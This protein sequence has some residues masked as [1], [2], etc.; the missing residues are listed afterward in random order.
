MKRFNHLFIPFISIILFSFS[1]LNGQ[2]NET[3][4]WLNDYKGEIPAGSY[5]YKYE[6][7]FFKKELCGI[8]IKSIKIDKKGSESV[9]RYELYL[10]DIDENAIKFKVTGK[11][12]TVSI[13]TK[14][15]QKFIKYFEDD[16]F[17][18][19]VSSLDI[20]TDQV[21]K[22]RALVDV[23]KE[24]LTDCKRQDKSWGS[25]K[26]S[27]GWLANNISAAN[28]GGT[29]YLQSFS[30]DGTRNYL[31][32]YNR[33]YNDSKGNEIVEVYSFNLADVDPAEVN[34][35]VSGKDLSVEL[36]TKNNDK[37]FRIMKD[38]AVQNYDNDFE[39]FVSSL[40]EAR[41]M[42]QALKF[43]IPLCKPV[44]KSFSD[45]NQALI[46][47]KE[48]VKEMTS[49]NYTYVQ[50]LDYENKP[51][52]I[53]SVVSKRTDSKGTTVED[54]YLLYLN[55]LEPEVALS[56]SG[57]DVLLKLNVKDKQKLI[58][59]FKDDEL[60]NYSNQIEI[61][62]GDIESARE[63]ANAFNYAI[64]NRDPGILKWADTGKAAAWISLNIGSITEAGKTYEQNLSF[65]AGNNYKTVLNLKTTDGSSETDEIF[66]FYM[67]DI[68]KDKLE[69][70]T[71][72]KKM[73]VEVTTGKE[74]VVKVFKSNEIQNYTS[75]VDL[76]FE[77]TRQAR[78]FI[79]A[80]KYLA[81]N[82]KQSE[83]SFSDSQSA[84][85]YISSNLPA[86][87]TGTYKYDQT[88]EM[89]DN[90]P[91]KIKFSVTQL[92]SKDVSTGYVYEFAMAD[93][94]PDAVKLEIS[95]KEMTVK[96]ETRGK[97][98]L[99][100]P[101]KNGEP[102]NFDYDFELFSDDVIVARNIVSAIK[103]MA[104]KCGK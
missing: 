76:M 27:L 56:V 96:L 42:V 17:K 9:N 51:D 7:S 57:K 21:D 49:G 100:K 59:T 43:S 6:Y 33:K 47:L 22:A 18:N 85:K 67:A 66:E 97:Q 92:D 11:Y 25:L 37:Y 16:E 2:E 90:D 40:E 63:L 77:D 31:V 89:I 55:E 53:V 70:S 80:M 54:K 74:K 3:V 41:D 61:I 14:K 23:L 84:F 5:T 28:S 36:N 35:N 24:K 10:S 79:G 98:K 60:Q 103:T 30:Y 13:E 52:G 68:D 1:M 72:G 45:V 29:E 93:I 58:R 78:N 4:D 88:I 87:S 73:F 65:D 75:S 15:S 104:G 83:K 94:N 95:G 32:V 82:V 71:S 81:S 44:Y 34:L 8:A 46:F 86:V 101:Y 50:L 64:L 19:Y 69:L 39:I 62:A 91:C 38:D 20:Y 102:Q 48:N 26:E 12:I 99:I